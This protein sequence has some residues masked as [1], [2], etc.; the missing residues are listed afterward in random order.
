MAAWQGELARGGEVPDGLAV[1]STVCMLHCCSLVEGTVWQV[2]G[3]GLLNRMF[4][5]S[6]WL[7]SDSNFQHLVKSLEEGACSHSAQYG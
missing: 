3:L 1:I 2:Y 7:N 4:S 5:A 6:M